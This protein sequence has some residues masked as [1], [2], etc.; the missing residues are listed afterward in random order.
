MGPKSSIIPAKFP[1]S[2][3]FGVADWFA[4]TASAT[5]TP[6]KRARPVWRRRNAS[7]Q[8]AFFVPQ[9]VAQAGPFPD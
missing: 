3:E 5:M 9:T 1:A 4:R 2:W 8:S 7:T 6:A